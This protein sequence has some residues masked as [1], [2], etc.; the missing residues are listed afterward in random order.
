[1]PSAFAAISISSTCPLESAASVSGTPA[2]PRSS[3][4][5]SFRSE[6]SS[7]LL[8]RTECPPLSLRSASLRPA[9]WKAQ[10]ASREHRQLRDRRR[11]THSDLNLLHFFF[12]E[13]NALRFRCDQHLFDLPV[14]K[15]SKRLGNTGNSEIVGAI[16]IQQ[17]LDLLH[18]RQRIEPSKRRQRFVE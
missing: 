18:V 7:L 2:T 14:G 13:L 5:Y 15:R 6:P 8:P 12:L 11:D 16:L 17:S 1:M 9:R 3:A 4:R 10:Q